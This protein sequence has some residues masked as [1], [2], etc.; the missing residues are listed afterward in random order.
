MRSGVE[1]TILVERSVWGIQ[2]SQRVL[3]SL[4]SWALRAQAGKKIIAQR[5]KSGVGEEWSG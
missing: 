2:L 5:I 1:V 4:A 3:A